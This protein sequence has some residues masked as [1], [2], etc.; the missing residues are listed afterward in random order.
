MFRLIK[1]DDMGNA[2]IEEYGVT[3]NEEYKRGE[4]LKFANGKLTKCGATDKP[5]FIA[6]ADYTA[7]A[8]D[9]N[10]LAVH[11]VNNNMIFETSNQVAVIAKVGD[12]VTLHTD[13]MQITST[14]TS[15]VAEL[16]Y[17]S[18]EALEKTGQVVHV[19]F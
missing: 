17:I 2:P 5:E 14:T 19:R 16:I 11:R 3:A 1:K 8:N 4:A 13:G 15:G 12:K 7:T 10:N 6:L 9:I 18:D